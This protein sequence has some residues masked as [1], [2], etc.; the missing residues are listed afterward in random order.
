VRLKLYKMAL[1]YVNIKYYN[2]L[3]YTFLTIY[4]NRYFT[5]MLLP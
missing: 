4:R 3:L 5:N 2:H 1:E